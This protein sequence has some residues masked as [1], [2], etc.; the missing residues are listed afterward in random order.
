MMR[1][2]SF[3]IPICLLIQPSFGE[4]QRTPLRANV[5]DP[6]YDVRELQNVAIVTQQKANPAWGIS[7][8]ERQELFEKAGLG[9]VI[10]TKQLD[11]LD[12]DRLFMSLKEKKLEQVEFQ[13][14]NLPKDALKKLKTLIEQRSKHE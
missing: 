6:S 7:V 4:E 3:L 11:E 8:K 1:F 9:Q 2:F 5:L 14:P 10:K 12:Q 13:F